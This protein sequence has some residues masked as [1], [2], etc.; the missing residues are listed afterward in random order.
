MINTHSGRHTGLDVYKHGAT[1]DQDGRNHAEGLSPFEMAAVEPLPRHPLTPQPTE[2]QKGI[3]GLLSCSCL[4]PATASGPQALP[5]STQPAGTSAQTVLAGSPS[6]QQSSDSN[7]GRL[8]E[9][10]S[11]RKVKRAGSRAYSDAEWQDAL[12]NFS[13]SD[14]AAMLEEAQVG[15]QLTSG[16]IMSNYHV[17]QC[18]W[19]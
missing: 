12:S 19:L 6:R 18:L 9:R 14:H 2:K 1:L 8:M 3:T 17:S 11:N 15:Q 4:C 5:G 13:S 16:Q 7:Y 10:L